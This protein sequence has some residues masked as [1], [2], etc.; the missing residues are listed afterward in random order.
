M[1]DT[2]LAELNLPQEVSCVGIF[3]G[4][5]GCEVAQFAANNFCNL[6]TSNH[7]YKLGRYEAALSET[8][9]LIDR[10]LLTIQGQKEL[11]RYVQK[12]TP[13]APIISDFTDS[14]A[15]ASAL[16][17]LLTENTIYISSLGNSHCILCKKGRAIELT[18]SHLPENPKETERIHKAGG[19]VEN[20]RV[21]GNLNISR[22]L[23]D[24]E[25]KSNPDLLQEDQMI[26]PLPEIRRETL[27][28]D[29]E[30][31]LLMT[32]SLR[33][34]MTAQQFVNFIKERQAVKSPNTIVEELITASIADHIETSYGLGCDNMTCILILF[35]NST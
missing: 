1:E 12:L 25:Y 30:F 23:G 2:K 26:S 7:K 6:L 17:A 9:L 22:S 16:I 19:I 4:H 35:N 28:K 33:D 27:D 10:Q 29:C 14:A 21:M 34:S 31:L 18:V 32:D 13:N 3:D 8:N 15:G 11:I 24:F 5:Y 20:G